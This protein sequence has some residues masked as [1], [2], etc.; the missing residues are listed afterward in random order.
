MCLID[1]LKQK[2]IFY[3]N[4]YVRFYTYLKKKKSRLCEQQYNV[5]NE[6]SFNIIYEIKCKEVAM[7]SVQI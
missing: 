3:T 1:C 7:S 5:F 6:K 2:C 4:I